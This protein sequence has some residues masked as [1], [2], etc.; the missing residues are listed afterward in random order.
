[1]ITGTEVSFIFVEVITFWKI[2][3]RQTLAININIAAK[4]RSVDQSILRMIVNLFGL[5][6]IIGSAAANAIYVNLKSNSIPAKTVII[7]ANTNT[8]S[9]TRDT[10]D[11]LARLGSVTWASR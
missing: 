6:R 3:E 2:P 10:L 1:M 4:N 8:H 11:I 9:K 7:F 5:K